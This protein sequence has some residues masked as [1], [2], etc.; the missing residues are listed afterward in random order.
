M[1]SMHTNVPQTLIRLMCTSRHVSSFCKTGNLQTGCLIKGARLSHRTCILRLTSLPLSTGPLLL[2]G[3]HRSLNNHPK[4]LPRLLWLPRNGTARS[5]K[6]GTPDFLPS[7]S[8]HMI[9]GMPSGH[10]GNMVLS[11]LPVPGKNPCVHIR[12]HLDRL[13]TVL[14]LPVLALCVGVFLRLQRLTASLPVR[15]TLPHLNCPHKRLS[16]RPKC[17]PTNLH[18]LTGSQTLTMALMHRTCLHHLPHRPL[19]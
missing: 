3:V 13:Q 5:H 18:S 14:A 7:N 15:I 9:S 19:V 12:N 10:L 8:I 6:F 16:H 1:P 17:P 11:D 4:A 2:N